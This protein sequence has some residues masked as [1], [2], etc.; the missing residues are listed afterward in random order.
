MNYN[1]CELYHSD[2]KN[3]SEINKRGNQ[4][5]Y[6]NWFMRLQCPCSSQVK[7][8]QASSVMTCDLFFGHKEDT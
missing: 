8:Y 6:S 7:K 3:S 4:G 2:E 1:E 5:D